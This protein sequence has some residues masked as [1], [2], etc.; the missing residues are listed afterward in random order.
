MDFERSPIGVDQ[1]VPLAAFDLLARV[2][3]TWAARFRGL[4]ALAIQ[5]RGRRTGLASDTLALTHDQ[6]VVDRLPRSVIAETRK[7]ALHR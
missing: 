3:A 2:I 5:H 6:M 4:G 7:P 1:R